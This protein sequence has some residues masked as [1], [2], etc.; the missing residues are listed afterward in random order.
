MA[1]GESEFSGNAGMVPTRAN[2]T[3][4]LQ[5]EIWALYATNPS[6]MD[7]SEQLGAGR[8]NI[9]DVPASYTPGRP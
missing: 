5:Q 7:G 8:S 9:G 1:S 4:T 2:T 3:D 6:G